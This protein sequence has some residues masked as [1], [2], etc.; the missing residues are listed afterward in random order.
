MADS[1][2]QDDEKKEKPGD[3]DLSGLQNFNFATNWSEATTAPSQRRDSGREPGA[4]DRS[5]RRE[6]RP[7]RRPAKRPASGEGGGVRRENPEAAGPSREG[8]DRRERRH[9]GP[10]HARRPERPA[11]PLWRESPFEVQVY[12]EDQILTTLARAMRQSL[13]TYELFEIARL[14]LEKP[15]RYHLSIR[16]ND[17]A[18]AGE[19]PAL[20][21]QSVPDGLPFVS[22][23]GAVDHVL[24][25]HLEKFFTVEQVEV[26]APK[27]TFQFIARCTLTGDDLSPPNFHRYQ[28]ILLQY[29][30]DRFPD[31]PF[32]RF[33]GSIE[34]VKNEEAVQKWLQGMTTQTRYRVA[35]EEAGEVLESLD[36]ARAHLLRQKKDQ[37]VRAHKMV[38]LPGK[39]LE[40]IIDQRIRPYVESSIEH[41]K[42]FPLDTA[43]GLRGRLRRQDFFIYKKGS[44]GVSYVCAVKRRFRQPG[45]TFSD[46]VEQLLKFIEDHEMIHAS[47]LVEKFLHV[48][49]PAA[50]GEAAANQMADENV[51][52][53]S[54]DL[55]WLLSE[56]YVTEFSD[57]RLLAHPAAQPGQPEPQA[58]EKETEVPERAESAAEAP[59]VEEAEP[60]PSEEAAVE[61]ADESEAQPGSD[62]AAPEEPGEIRSEPL[63]EEKP[64]EEEQAEA[65]NAPGAPEGPRTQ[66]S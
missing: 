65:A 19:P 62:E 21:Y 50:E 63:S 29:H 38:K 2:D 33:R 37:V 66:S 40:Q 28:S 59:G 56:G 60:H 44:R 18:A 64:A 20:L 23:E 15:E 22:E 61:S 46:S 34:T 10:R 26:E 11:V 27:G 31:M 42:R 39:Q 52:R 4:R 43:N 54:I 36:Q 51:K 57:G 32:E 1:S 5:F 53:M 8:T 17:A 7:D 30:Q 35:G 55:R 58:T 9:E 16:Y 6:A 48:A 49:P 12:P 47:E 14:V 41:Q 3:V 13:R 45:Q 25:I 24:R